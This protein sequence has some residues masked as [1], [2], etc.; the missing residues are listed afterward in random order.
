[1]ADTDAPLEDS[2]TTVNIATVYDKGSVGNL[3]QV[4]AK[5][6][7]GFAKAILFYLFL[8]VIF[9][10]ASSY[11][12]T[13]FAPENTPLINVVTIIL[14]ITKTAVPSIVSL[15]LGFYFGKRETPADGGSN[16][17]A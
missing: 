1:M 13:Q 14:D 6:L 9:V 10:F 2:V 16:S 15:V 12:M 17:V 3:Q 8:L 5:D 4:S 7:L 11:L